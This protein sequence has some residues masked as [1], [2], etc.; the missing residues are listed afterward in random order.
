MDKWEQELELIVELESET[1]GD[2]EFLV[3]FDMYKNGYDYKT[4]ADVI[5][6]WNEKLS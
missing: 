4:K 6:Y 1:V 2:L 3:A 5:E